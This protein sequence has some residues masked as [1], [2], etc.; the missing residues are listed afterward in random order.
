MASFKMS[1][2]RDYWTFWAEDVRRA[3]C[4]LYAR[5]ALEI[6][7]DKKLKGLAEQAR[8]GQPPANLILGAVHFLL[9]R[10]ADHPVR[11]FYPTLGGKGDGDLESAFPLFRDFV[12]QHE[13]QVF[14]L[15]TS[16]VTNTNEVGRSALLH[17]GFRALAKL[18]TE[19]LHLIE[20]GASAG[21]NLLWHR[22]GVRFARDGMAAATIA[23]D[24]PLVLDCAL[25]GNID[26]PSTPTPAIGRR[27][28]IELNPVDL[29]DADD[30]DWLRA[31]IFP[32]EVGRLRRLEKA[33]AMFQQSPCEVRHGDALALLPEAMA[34]A[35]PQ[36]TL[37][38]YHTIVLYQ[39]SREMREAFDSL[40]VT[41]GLRRPVFHLAFEFDG[42]D[43]TLLLERHFDGSRD[44]FPLAISHP[45]GTWLEW[46]ATNGISL[47]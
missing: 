16:R 10:G 23:P 21:L 47:R 30:R 19:P 13:S 33:I 37:C 7:R 38:V 31:L 34:E 43:Y 39:F 9:L 42:R 2:T 4:E 26:P 6:G 1:E 28:G 44:A 46:K 18:S 40:L 41:A 45:H 24:A 20:V 14:Q 11:A 32:T 29:G 5:L 27:V 25:R 15:I 36:T 22:F 12:H 3:G 35:S 17:S 8:K